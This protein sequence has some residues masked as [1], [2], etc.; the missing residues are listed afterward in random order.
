MKKFSQ[1]LTES[2]VEKHPHSKMREYSK[3][4]LDWEHGTEYEKYSKPRFPHAFKDREHFQKKYDKAPLRHL[5]D[6]EHKHLGNY[7]G[8]HENIESVHRLMDHRRDVGRVE[9]DLQHGHT[10]PPIVLKHKHGLHLMAGNTR[11]SVASAHK[12]R[13]P[14]KVIDVDKDE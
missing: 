6:H 8:D 7:S 10:A 5:T 4:E 2:T 12:K 13:L 1:Y 11:M 14:V 3:S 9:H